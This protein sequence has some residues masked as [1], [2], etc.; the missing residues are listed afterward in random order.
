[1]KSLV[2]AFVLLIEDNFFILDNLRSILEAEGAE[3]E[4][5]MTVEEGLA[6]TDRSYDVAVLDIRLP[7]GEVFGL[8]DELSASNTPLIFYSGDTTSPSLQT[9][10]PSAVAL[11]KPTQE[12]MFVDAVRQRLNA[13]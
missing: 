6:L 3:V 2:G 4:A 9:R 13:A 10:F 7:D 5:A 1:M 11:E 12:A 8:A